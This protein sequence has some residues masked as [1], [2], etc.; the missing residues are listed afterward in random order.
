MYL[1]RKYVIR[2][3]CYTS[4]HANEIR[5]KIPILH[6][7]IWNENQD[8]KIFIHR[9]MKTEPYYIISII[10]ILCNK[11]IEKFCKISV[12]ILASQDSK[13]N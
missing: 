7:N 4:R 5:Q 10:F 8:K 1:S 6:S 13:G 12:K 2:K 9:Q 11:A 3:L